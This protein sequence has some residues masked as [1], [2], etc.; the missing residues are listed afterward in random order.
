MTCCGGVPRAMYRRVF[1]WARTELIWLTT[2]SS[3]GTNIRKRRSNPRAQSI[4][5]AG[6]ENPV[7]STVTK[8]LFEGH[9]CLTPLYSRCVHRK[10]DHN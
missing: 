8:G 7:A 4:A 9:G 2:P 6:G 1:T 5:E 3:S 10:K